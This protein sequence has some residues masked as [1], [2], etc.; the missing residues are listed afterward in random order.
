MTTVTHGAGAGFGAPAAALV[1]GRLGQTPFAVITGS[2]G[3]TDVP[4]SVAGAGVAVVFD[5][6]GEVVAGGD[7]V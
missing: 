5:T 6:D 1:A 2:V 3:A 4:G 7:V